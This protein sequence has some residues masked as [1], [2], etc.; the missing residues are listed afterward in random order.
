MVMAARKPITLKMGWHEW[1]MLCLCAMLWG[2]AYVFNAVAIKE[3][4]HLTITFGRL[5]VASLFLQIVLRMYGLSMPRGWAV[6]RSFF[7]MTLLSN[8]GPYL[9][10]LRGQM[11]TT[12]GLA[13]V[14]TATT[15]LFTILLAHAFTHDERMTANKLIGVLVGIAGVAIVVGFDAWAGAS[16]SFVAKLALV[17]ASFMYAIGSIY[18]KRFSGLPPLVIAACIM[19]SGALVSLPLSFYFDRPWTLAMP[20]LEVLLAVLCTGIFGSALAAISY[21]RLFTVAGATNAM[22]VTLLLPVTPIIGGAI[23]LGERLA[24]REIAG[25][26][27][28]MLA[29]VII[30]GRMFRMLRRAGT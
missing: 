29:L 24:P 7:M 26:I 15:P 27:V 3:L 22:L 13:A 6:W 28:I 23:Y 2:S 11:G 25:G 21:F 20:S 1:L 10:V 18:A 5:V 4:P 30:D 12:S 8:I 14:L 9:L 17:A 16:A 19:T